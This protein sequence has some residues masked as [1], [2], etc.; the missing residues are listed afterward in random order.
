MKQKE[1][2]EMMANLIVN[3]GLMCSGS[4]FVITRKLEGYLFDEEESAEIVDI[5]KK[6]KAD[7]TS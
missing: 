2:Y 4:P 5:I 3:L 7:L 1:E 6:R